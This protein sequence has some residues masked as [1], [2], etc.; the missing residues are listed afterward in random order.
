MEN[1]SLHVFIS[2]FG[3]PHIEEKLKILRNNMSII[4]TYPWS[5]VD[6]TI[7]CY[8]NTHF[9]FLE[10]FLNVQIIRDKQVVGQYIQKYLVPY[11]KSTAYT[12][13]LCI[14]DDIELQ[15]NIDWAKIIYYQQ[16]FQFD[17]LSPSMTQDSKYQ[18]VYMLQD[19]QLVQPAI[20]ITSALEYF[21]YFMTPRSYAKYYP[22]VNGNRNPWMWGLDMLLYKQIGLKLGIINHMQMKHWFKNESYLSRPDINPCDGYNYILERYNETTDSLANQPS[23]MYV[24]LEV[25]YPQQRSISNINITT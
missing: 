1:P 15:D 8:D 24:I 25:A 13:I 23:I 11:T 17:I 5:K 10:D 4:N 18:F 14:L 20:K 3:S 22:H 6:Y 12:Y 19:K 2:G 7:C 21:C 16:C 9:E